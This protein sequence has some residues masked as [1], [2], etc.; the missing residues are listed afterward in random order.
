MLA[1][2]AQN[3]QPNELKHILGKQ[4]VFLLTRE[5]KEGYPSGYLDEKFIV[6]NIAD[7]DKHFYVCGPD[8]IVAEINGIL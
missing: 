4:A 7:F 6:Q 8:K 2:V 5:N 3:Y 1:F